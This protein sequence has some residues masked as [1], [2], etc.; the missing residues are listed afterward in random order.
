ME[1]KDIVAGS[2]YPRFLLFMLIFVAGAVYAAVNFSFNH[3]EAVDKL[4]LMKVSCVTE[5]NNPVFDDGLGTAYI[6][7]SEVKRVKTILG[8]KEIVSQKLVGKG[9]YI[10]VNYIRR[11]L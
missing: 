1:T 5:R 10:K 8:N 4:G 6:P 7:S 3:K 9:Q 2:C 11:S